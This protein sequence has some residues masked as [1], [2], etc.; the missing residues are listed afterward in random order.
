MCENSILTNIDSQLQVPVASESSAVGTPKKHRRTITIS[1]RDE[2]YGR[3]NNTLAF[4]FRCDPAL[5]DTGMKKLV[6]LLRKNGFTFNTSCD[7]WIAEG[8]RATGMAQQSGW[9]AR[10]SG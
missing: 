2:N 1:W 8:G 4:R 3:I 9:R 6:R 10:Q 7:S 5:S